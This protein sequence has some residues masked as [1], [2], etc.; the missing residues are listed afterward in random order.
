MEV[1]HQ[2]LDAKT[3]VSVNAID[4]HVRRTHETCA[5]SQRRRKLVEDLMASYDYPVERHT[6]DTG[7]P[8]LRRQSSV[9]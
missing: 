4:D 5:E 9:R 8:V 3:L 6:T 1:Q 7:L 2:Q